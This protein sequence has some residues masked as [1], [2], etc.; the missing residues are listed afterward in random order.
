MNTKLINTIKFA[1]IKSI[2][3]LIGYLFLGMAFGIL[4]FLAGYDY[5]YA[6]LTSMTIYSGTLQFALVSF[7][8]QNTDLISIILI[9]GTMNFRYLFYGISSLER[10]RNTGWRKPFLIHLTVDETFSIQAS[11]KV[12]NNVSAKDFYFL[13]ALFDYIYWI[14]GA[15]IGNLLASYITFDS[16]GIEFIMTALF[17]VLF[18]EQVK[19]NHNFKSGLI[20][21]VVSLLSLLIFGKNYFIIFALII[22]TIILIGFK[23]KVIKNG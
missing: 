9:S 4:L 5:I 3:I 16:T 11:T 20:G 23:G 14:I 15:L 21:I 17:I 7:L 1:F 13:L 22:I 10:F 6:I 12:P 18:M 8:T 2:P 19:S